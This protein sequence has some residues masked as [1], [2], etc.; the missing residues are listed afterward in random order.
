MSEL[1]SY[2]INKLKQ[3]KELEGF[4]TDKDLATFMG[5]STVTIHDYMI[6]K[7]KQLKSD[8]LKYLRQKGYSYDWLLDDAGDPKKDVPADSLKTKIT[9]NQPVSEGKSEETP[10]IVEQKQPEKMDVMEHPFFQ[11]VQGESMFLREL[12]TKVIINKG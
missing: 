10:T 1:E 11:H 4:K 5:V 6:G 3:I 2:W 12:V 7:N 8:N 9:D